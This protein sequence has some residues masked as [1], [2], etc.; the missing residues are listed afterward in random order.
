MTLPPLSPFL[1]QLGAEH[2]GEADGRAQMRLTLAAPHLNTYEVAHGGVLMALLDAVMAA[3]ARSRVPGVA[4]FVTLEMKTS[5][6]KA[7]EGT[8]AVAGE[9]MHLTP[10]LAFT[11]GWVRDA[12]NDVC[13]HAT[14]TFKPM[15]ALKPPVR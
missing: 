4:G 9:V 11:Q 10:T 2:L 13:A 12:A 14:G 7:A 6:F 15:R 8:L 1:A 3:A 5:F